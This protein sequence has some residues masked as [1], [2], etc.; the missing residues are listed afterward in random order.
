M[1]NRVP[2]VPLIFKCSVPIN[3]TQEIFFLKSPKQMY[4]VQGGVVALSLRLQ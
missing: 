4:P 1:V 3:N 2:K